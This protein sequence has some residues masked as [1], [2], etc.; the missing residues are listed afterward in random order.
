MS[1]Q[2]SAIPTFHRQSRRD[3]E[4]I[5]SKFNIDEV[6]TKPSLNSILFILPVQNSAEEDNKLLLNYLDGSTEEFELYKET[7]KGSIEK[8]TSND[9]VAERT[10]IIRIEKIYNKR[11]AVII[12]SPLYN[13]AIFNKAYIDIAE[14][15]KI[16]T[17]NGK[18]LIT[19]DSVE[20]FD[21]RIKKLENKFIFGNQEPEEAL[22]G[23]E[24][25]TIYAKIEL[26]D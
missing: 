19:Y 14:F 18:E 4:D 21:D 10:A 11:I 22:E 1:Q 6:I 12:N 24:I 25:G 7:L 26:G 5:C 13:E 20:D 23:K 2:L 8:A 15:Y 9:L 3:A 16:P 17:V